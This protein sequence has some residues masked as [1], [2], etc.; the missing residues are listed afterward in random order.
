[1]PF[2]RGVSIRA[3]RVGSD[4]KHQYFLDVKV[5]FQSAL[6]VWGATKMSAPLH[7]GIGVSIRAPRVGSD[8]SAEFCDYIIKRFN[9]RSPCGERL[10]VRE[11]AF[12]HARV[13]IRAPR[14]GSDRPHAGVQRGG[15]VSIRAPRVG[16]DRLSTP[17]KVTAKSFNPRSPC[18]ERRCD[19]CRR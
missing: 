10:R 17:K 11:D 13:S 16:S 6:P 1:M 15:C 3:P 9:P 14:V 18:G 19:F 8:G 2:G 5:L 4:L 7:A 12:R